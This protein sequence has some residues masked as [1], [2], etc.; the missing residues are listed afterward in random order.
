MEPKE[1]KS[2]ACI[3]EDGTPQCF[4]YHA[5]KG[6]CSLDGKVHVGCMVNFMPIESGNGESEI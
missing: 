2:C 4:L 1:P 3:K 6:Y 5:R